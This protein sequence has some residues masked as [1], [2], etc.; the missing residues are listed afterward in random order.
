MYQAYWGLAKSPFRGHLDPRSFYQGPPQD[1]A[2]ARLHFLV[3][4]RRTLGLLL[5]EAG[6][7]KSLLLEVFAKELGIVNREHALVNLMGTSRTELLWSLAGQ[8]GVE[9]SRAR[10]EFALYRA[11]GDH[12]LANRYQQIA[13]VLLLDD[14]DEAQGEV[15]EE[16]IRLAQLNQ[17]HDARLTVVLTAQSERLHRLG[18]RILELAEL[19]VDLEGW[20]LDDTTGFVKQSLAEAGRSTPIFSEGALRR[21]HELTG[22]VPRRIKQLADL[23]LLGG[24]GSNLAQIESEL[25]EAVYQELGVDTGTMV[26]MG[27]R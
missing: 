18:A 6:S 23:A 24:A 8:L 11:L 13:T 10:G 3:E 16:V 9:S 1:E 25:I 5:G 27:G 15:L 7:G 14:A 19:R 20:D 2:L 22:G 12:I 17:T 21:L 4:E 26:T